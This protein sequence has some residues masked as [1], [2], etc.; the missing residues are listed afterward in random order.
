[1]FIV[2]AA[3]DSVLSGAYFMS[4]LS[5]LPARSSESWAAVFLRSCRRNDL[6]AVLY[7]LGAANG[8][9]GRFIQSI[10]YDGFVGAMLALDINVIVLFACFAGISAILDEDHSGRHEEIRPSDLSVAAIFLAL[11][12]LP[13]FPVSWIAVTGLSFYILLFARENSARQ[14]G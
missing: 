12:T 6:F 9:L 3:R 4:A 10:G 14:R 1:L 5:E 13:I 7:I 11:V 2:A 8:L